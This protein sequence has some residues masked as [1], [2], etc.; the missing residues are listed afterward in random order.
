[1]KNG[2]KVLTENTYTVHHYAGSWVKK[3]DK[4][5]GKIYRTL[6]RIFGEKFANKIRN[7][8]GRKK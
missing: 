4:L 7:V 2:K 5:R 1:M 6:N 8:F 3:S